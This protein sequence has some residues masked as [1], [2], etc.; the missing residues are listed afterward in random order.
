M[1]AIT[2]TRENLYDYFEF[3]D[4]EED[5]KNDGTDGFSLEQKYDKIGGN[6]EDEGFEEL[7]AK[8]FEEIRLNYEDFNHERSCMWLEEVKRRAKWVRGETIYG[9]SREK[10]YTYPIWW[11]RDK[12][13]IGYYTWVL[14]ADGYVSFSFHN[15]YTSD[16][17]ESTK[18]HQ[19]IRPSCLY[20]DKNCDELTEL[21]KNPKPVP[22]VVEPVK[23]VKKLLIIESDSEE[24]SD[25]EA[26]DK[27]DECCGCNE[28]FYWRSLNYSSDDKGTLYCDDCMPE[29][30]SEEESDEE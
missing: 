9:Y 26:E 29:S 1:S 7:H 17:T 28:K 21:K 10:H 15:G 22:V 16:E 20:N 18:H 24:E 14:E 13:K 12:T 19:Y 6:D 23:P 2:I 4:W 30:D 27:Q 8:M 5:E 3:K 11:S 25:E